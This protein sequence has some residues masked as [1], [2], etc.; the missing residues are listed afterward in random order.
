MTH[1][2][3]RDGFFDPG[4]L[5][6][7]SLRTQNMEKYLRVFFRKPTAPGFTNVRCHTKNALPNLIKI[8]STTL[9]GSTVLTAILPCVEA[10]AWDCPNII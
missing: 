7:A 2:M 5:V 3:D 9:A 1:L 10:W 4:T 8:R 6:R